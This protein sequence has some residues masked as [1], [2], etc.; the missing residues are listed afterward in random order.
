MREMLRQMMIA[1]LVPIFSSI[2]TVG[3]MCRA[4]RLV[5]LAR[6]ASWKAKLGAQ[7]PGTEIY[8]WVVIHNPENVCIGSRCSIAEFTHFWGGGG[9]AIG[10]DVLIA[11]HVVIT[12]LTHDKHATRY[13][14]SLLRA[15]VTIEDNV[16][17]GAGAIIL[18][19]VTLG[20]GAIVGAGA[21]VTRD[22]PSGAVVCGVPARAIEG[23]R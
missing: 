10:D 12:S 14:D 1:G 23:G 18:P 21:V 11:S 13:R 16:W 19:G 17:I 15:P 7:G 3:R 4:N 8:P 6:H 9:V 20:R 5:S 2:Q 22:V